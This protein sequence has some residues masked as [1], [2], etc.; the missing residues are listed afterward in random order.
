MFVPT[1]INTIYEA[2]TLTLLGWAVC[3]PLVLAN[4]DFVTYSEKF[5]K[6]QICLMNLIS[7]IATVMIL[8]ANIDWSYKIT[9]LFWKTILVVYSRWRWWRAPPTLISILITVLLG[10]GV[11]WGLFHVWLTRNLSL[12][13]CFFV[14]QG[15]LLSQGAFALGYGGQNTQGNKVD[16]KTFI[17][18]INKLRKIILLRIGLSLFVL[19]FIHSDIFGAY[20]VYDLTLPQLFW[21]LALIV[22]GVIFPVLTLR[23]VR[24]SVALKARESTAIFVLSI[25]LCVFLADLQAK[26]L[27]I[28]Q[29]IIF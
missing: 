1:S 19:R 2:M 16:Q 14:I 8:L 9:A 10:I 12:A 4:K 22:N 20:F 6:S 13:I 17:Q 18:G 26:H 25:L 7:G 15:T 28:S 11:A 3:Y 21:L 5:L 23:L 29:R 27:L 24:D